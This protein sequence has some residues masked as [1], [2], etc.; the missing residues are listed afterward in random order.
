[1]ATGG[2]QA[3]CLIK[4][5][6]KVQFRSFRVRAVIQRVLSA[7]VTVEGNEI[8]RIG[9]GLLTL[10]GVENGDS[11]ADLEW[12]MK[13][14]VQLRIFSDAEGK[15]N[16]SLID[17]GGEHL[18]VS[19][20]TLLGDASKGLRPSFVRAAKPDVAKAM[21]EEALAL[22]TQLGV[23]TKPGQFQADMRVELVNDGP[24]TLILN[25][26]E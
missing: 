12:M 6:Y 7:S 25:S 21:Y 24:V 23:V 14:I 1:M 10:L 26:R 13:K 19:Q 5:G 3:R 16:R 4:N 15:M 20:F 8:S 22:S 2:K 9:P 18:L 11:R 17:V